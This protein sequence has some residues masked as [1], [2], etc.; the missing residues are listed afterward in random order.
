MIRRIHIVF[1]LLLLAAA[2]CEQTGNVIAPLND[3]AND[4]AVDI[5]QAGIEPDNLVE[6]H[7]LAFVPQ[8]VKIEQGDTVTWR[9][10]DDV[11]HN[12]VGFGVDERLEPGD[13]LRHTFDEA[14]TFHY[15][16]S[17]HP[18]MEGTVTVSGGQQPNQQPEGQQ[19]NQQPTD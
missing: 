12:I 8:S 10:T 9:N 14:G 1:A 16:C 6:I 13:T 3:S 17:I 4:S 19:P 5:P 2:A 7:D 18:G 15:I 11:A